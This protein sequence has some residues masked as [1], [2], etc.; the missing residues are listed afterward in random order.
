MININL[1]KLLH[2]EQVICILRPYNSFF[3]FNCISQTEKFAGHCWVISLVLHNVGRGD[4]GGGREGWR[5][6]PALCGVH[7]VSREASGCHSISLVASLWEGWLLTPRGLHLEWKEPRRTKLG[8][9]E[10]F[11]CYRK[12][13]RNDISG[14]STL[15][16]FGNPHFPP[17]S[18]AR[19]HFHWTF[20]F[21]LHFCPP[22][23]K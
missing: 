22:C 14:G 7:E 18:T 12:F 16:C 15:S 5:E 8:I 2:L 21:C 11:H 3:F 4:Q 9:S 23:N 20:D 6:D 17:W 19:F 13:C 1:L 10:I